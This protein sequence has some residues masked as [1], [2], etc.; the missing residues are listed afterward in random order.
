MIW[1]LSS[2]TVGSFIWWASLRVM[3][4]GIITSFSACSTTLGRV[5]ISRASLFCL[6]K[7]NKP[8]TILLHLSAWVAIIFKSSRRASS[9]PYWSSRRCAYIKTTPSGLLS[10]WA[11]PAASWPMLANFSA[12]MRVSRVFFSFSFD[13]AR[14]SIVSFSF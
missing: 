4:G 13:S 5:V 12:C 10:S 9:E 11:M 7:C 8:E 1:S 3:L 2:S 14:F 6:A